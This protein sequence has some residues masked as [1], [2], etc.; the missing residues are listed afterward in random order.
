MAEPQRD[1]KERREKE[2]EPNLG[3]KILRNQTT[4]SSLFS[5]YGF[6]FLGYARDISAI[7]GSM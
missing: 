3:E 4:A 6:G 1:G 2:K 7:V 5:E